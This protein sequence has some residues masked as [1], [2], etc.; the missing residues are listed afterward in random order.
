MASLVADPRPGY[1]CIFSERM[2]LKKLTRTVHPVL[3]PDRPSYV[4]PKVLVVART[5][6]TTAALIRGSPR[7]PLGRLAFYGTTRI[8]RRVRY[9]IAIEVKAD[10]TRTCRN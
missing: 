7:W 5:R 1:R 2:E 8:S 10:A 6:R 4:A 3:S 9:L